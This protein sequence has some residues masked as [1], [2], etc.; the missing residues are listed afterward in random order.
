MSSFLSDTVKDC[1]S[2]LRRHGPTFML[3]GEG[4]GGSGSERKARSDGR[5]AR[6]GRVLPPAE[7]L[8]I[9]RPYQRIKLAG[10]KRKA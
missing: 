1:K 3:R 5:K 7:K 2:L 4:I 6:A 9:K 10:R 8:E